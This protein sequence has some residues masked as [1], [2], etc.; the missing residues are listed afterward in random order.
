M[1]SCAN[2]KIIVIT[3]A[4]RGLGRALVEEFSQKNNFLVLCAKNLKNLKSVC[5][6][7][8]KEGT[9]CCAS[10]IDVSNKK[11]V[12]KFIRTTLKK[13]SKIDILVNNAG[14]IQKAKPI[15]KITD[16]EY[17]KCLKTNLDSIFY[18]LREVIPP[19]RKRGSGI[20]VTISSTA[21]RQG[22]SHFAAY[23]ASKFAVTGL[24]QSAA[25][26]LGGY[27]IRCLTILPGAMNTD[28]RKYIL[29]EEDANKQQS[30]ESV[31][32]IVK[33]AI[34]NEIEFSNGSEIEIR[35]GKIT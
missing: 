11:E 16:Q 20:I 10:K 35:D 28:M 2:K 30:P 29:G 31:A 7:L 14:V 8:K 13:F 1:R 6:K 22:N 15:E 17:E 32:K 23:S 33:T 3:G 19:M 21:G 25:R 12:I 4:S 18:A 27:G 9:E 24:M 5:R 34:E 26:Y